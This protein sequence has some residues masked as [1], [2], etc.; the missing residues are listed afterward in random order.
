MTPRDMT[1]RLMPHSL[2]GPGA[3]TTRAYLL[4]AA[5]LLVMLGL[6]LFAIQSGAIDSLNASGLLGIRS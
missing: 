1:V 2:N 3:H 4:I 6:G 5:T